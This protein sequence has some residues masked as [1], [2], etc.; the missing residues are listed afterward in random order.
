MLLSMPSSLDEV[1]LADVDK[2]DYCWYVAA[3]RVAVERVGFTPGAFG[4]I[5]NS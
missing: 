3:G 2:D 4:L 5:I 1:T